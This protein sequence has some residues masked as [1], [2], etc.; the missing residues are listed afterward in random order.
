MCVCVCVGMH[1]HVSFASSGKAH[2]NKSILLDTVVQAHG[3]VGMLLWG[4]VL[5][6]NTVKNKVYTPHAYTFTY[7]YIIVKGKKKLGSK[8]GYLM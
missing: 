1:L 6:Q 3:G 2:I 7:T 4:I 5:G 8:A